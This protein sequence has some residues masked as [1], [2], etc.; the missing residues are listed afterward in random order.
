MME[1]Y[2]DRGILQDEIGIIS[3]ED[4]PSEKYKIMKFSEAARELESGSNT[5]SLGEAYLDI[6]RIYGPQCPKLRQE[7]SDFGPAYLSR[8]LSER[9]I[10]VS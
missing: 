4:R 7:I 1:I 9:S 3:P 2:R 8:C 5:L 10:P 6:I